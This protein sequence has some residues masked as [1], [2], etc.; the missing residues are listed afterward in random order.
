MKNL[1]ET[2]KPITIGGVS[3]IMMGAGTMYA[4]QPSAPEIPEETTSEASAEDAATTMLTMD[5]SM[6]FSEAFANARATSGPGSLFC[7]RGNIYGTYYADEWNGMSDEDKEL[8]AQRASSAVQPD[9]APAQQE[10][11]P[12]AEE[13]VI[14]DDALIDD[15]VQIASTETAGKEEGSP[16]GTAS[17]DD[18][19]SNDN[20]V[21]IVGFSEIQVSR[22]HSVTM[23]ELDV[24]GQRV[25]VIDVDKDGVPDLAM[26]DLNH[27][28]QMD[29]GE[30]IDLQTGEA[31]SLYGD[32]TNS[33][34]VD[35][36]MTDV[37]LATL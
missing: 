26:T 23:E 25:A 20:D 19:V 10:P 32:D 33:L 7:W 37:D 17:W 34:P 35:D 4:V 31:V 12:V 28:Q 27:N 9:T 22:H 8:F 24:N 36:G 3:G 6:S 21:R 15:D 18:L 11:R 5:D 2:W 13:N 14:D 29:E 16:E 30:V 1:K